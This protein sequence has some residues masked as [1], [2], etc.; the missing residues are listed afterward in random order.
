ML[1][2]SIGSPLPLNKT[3]E[4]SCLGDDKTDCTSNARCDGKG[5][6]RPLDV[7]RFADNQQQSRRK[8]SRENNMV[9]NGEPGPPLAKNSCRIASYCLVPTAPAPR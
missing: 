1:S 5:E 9:F 2:V 7:T 6:C 3:K 4:S 8:W